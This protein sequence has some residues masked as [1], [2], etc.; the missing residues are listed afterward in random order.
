MR[1]QEPSPRDIYVED[2][3]APE[4]AALKSV[5]VRLQQAGRWGVNIGAAEGK[6]LQVLIHMIG[7]RKIVEIGAL[8]GYS[9]AWMARALPADARL[10]TI[11][12]DPTAATE[13]RKTFAD[14][15][16]AEKVTLLEGDASEKLHELAKDAP[17][18]MVFI[19][20][21]KS[22]YP[23]YLAWAELN[24]RKGGLIVADNTLLGG[25]V[26]AN[27]K[28]GAMSAKQWN[29]MREFN[30]SIADSSRFASVLLPTVE[31]LTIAYRK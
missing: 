15:G 2:L 3:Y 26:L 14:C 24:V 20:A 25:A 1:K 6:L 29:G 13:A 11:E 12:R 16:V 21:N 19:D 7:A 4:D 10:W 27:E 31:G 18:D 5:R 23:E 22:A 9:G 17:F 8:Y 28:P 30:K